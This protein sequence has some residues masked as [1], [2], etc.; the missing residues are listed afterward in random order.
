ML[1]SIVKTEALPVTTFK[2]VPDYAINNSNNEV[3][4]HS[5]GCIYLTP[6]ERIKLLA[7]QYMF[8]QKASFDIILKPK[9][10]SFYMTTPKEFSNLIENTMKTVWNKSTIEPIA[11][12]VE[13]FTRQKTEVCE[14]VLKDYNFKSFS[15]S[16]SD[17]YPLTNMIG[18]TKNLKDNEKVRASI[19]IEPM[20]RRNWIAIAKDEYKSFQ[21]GKSINNEMSR[22]EKIAKLGFAGIEGSLSLYI[23]YK[24][25]L[26]ES[27]FGLVMPDKREDEKQTIEIKL[28]SLEAMKEEN[29]MNNLNP[30]TI[31]KMTSEAFRCRVVILS[32]SYEPTRAK[33]N[34]LAVANAYKDLNGDNELTPRM[35]SKWEQDRL[36][37][38][39]HENNV[40]TSNVCI[41]S[42]KEVAKLIQLPQA[43]LQREY[44]LESIDTRELDI[45]EELQNGKV[46]IGIADKQ[47]KKIPAFWATPINVMSLAKV[48]VGP[49]GSGK[50]T[51][52]KRTIKDCHKAGY[53]NIVIDYVE[54]CELAREIS[55][56]L[57]PGEK[58]EIVLGG[59]NNVPALA[60]NEV[61]KLIKEGMDPWERIR[62]ANLISEQVE[63]LINAVTDSSTGELTAPMLR[64]LHAACM[65]TFIRPGARLSDVFDIL[66]RWDKRHLAVEYAKQS[67]C[68]DA[69]DDTFWDLTELDERDKKTGEII[70]TRENLIIGITNRIIVLQKNPYLKAMLKA[71]IN[72]SQDFTR[73]IEQ[74]KS[75]FI[76]IPQYMF[77]NQ[78]VRDII[79]TFF[80]SRIWL[81]IQLRKDNAN[82]RL[83]NVVFDEVH[84][85]PTTARFLANHVTEFRRHRLGLI[86]SCHFLK[87]FRDLFDALKSS[88][89]SYVLI[90]GTE[91]EN[92]EKLREE[93][94]PFSVEEVMAIK[95]WHSL[96]IVNYGNQ[97]AR[98]V[99][100]MPK[101]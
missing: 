78:M 50:T 15:T 22:K 74:G 30:S 93:L 70:S 9:S 48:F 37:K 25:L 2:L 61:S 7:G 18:V 26:F 19:T 53:S 16:K 69:D 96:N 17:L 92:L 54:S 44:Q 35:L 83:C 1:D 23:E 41:C 79:T 59:R 72:Q 77:P 71:P 95:K 56:A 73:Y 21:K 20:K 87:Q 49:Q 97:Y 84:Q 51:A 88:G 6:R 99:T 36:F 13:S 76:Q 12:E 67:N 46:L 100:A 90:A 43:D 64:Y 65:V 42:D 98:F 5:L 8:P 89:V 32:E 40:P 11:G 60:Y 85:V 82:A 86:I 47:G 24:M 58:I 39:V 10:A 94:S 75:V 57:P 62:L 27:V 31:Y 33:L 91:K 14:L 38:A 66:R 81:A 45:P 68:F 34:M 52:L 80:V 28:D 63:Y 4:V 55:A 29:K 3:I 101:E